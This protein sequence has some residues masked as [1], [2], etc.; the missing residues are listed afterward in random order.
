MIKSNP[1]GIMLTPAV[2]N[3]LSNTAVMTAFSTSLAGIFQYEDPKATAAATITFATCDEV[4]LQFYPKG[5]PIVR[6]LV[7]FVV[8]G[9]FA[10]LVGQRVNKDFSIIKLGIS[11]GVVLFGFAL[12]A[13]A[14][15]YKPSS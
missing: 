12:F 8:G 5:D 9:Y 6:G 10:S 15:G 11:H 2:S 3:F 13:A 4:I 7:T 1:E 14:L